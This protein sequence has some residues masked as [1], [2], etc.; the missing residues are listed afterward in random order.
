MSI[1]PQIC[2]ERFETIAGSALFGTFICLKRVCTVVPRATLFHAI[3]SS[4]DIRLDQ[5]WPKLRRLTLTTRRKHHS[6]LNNGRR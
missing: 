2:E 5:A 3:I 4:L 1:R 6:S